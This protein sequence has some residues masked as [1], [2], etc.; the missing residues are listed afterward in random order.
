MAYTKNTW[1]SGDPLTADKLN[2]IENGIEEYDLVFPI[3]ATLKEPESGYKYLE[4]NKT[5]EEISLAF[6]SGKACVVTVTDEIWYYSTLCIG[7]YLV[8][9]IRKGARTLWIE[10]T[11]SKFP[12]SWWDGSDYPRLYELR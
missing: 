12:F 1:H 10:N 7:E 3:T 5:G 9:S 11:R 6:Q 4:L 8:S 2:H